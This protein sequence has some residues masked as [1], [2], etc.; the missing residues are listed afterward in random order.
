MNKNFDD[1]PNQPT[2]PIKGDRED[3]IYYDRN[4]ENKEY[5]H[6]TEIAYRNKGM[7]KTTSFTG[8][9]FVRDQ[10]GDFHCLNF[11]PNL[12]VDLT[13]MPV[14]CFGGNDAKKKMAD[15]KINNPDFEGA[16]FQMPFSKTNA[17]SD[18]EIYL[19]SDKVLKNKVK[20]IQPTEQ[21]IEEDEDKRIHLIFQ[22][23]SL[24]PRFC[25]YLS[26][27]DKIDFLEQFKS[28]LEQKITS[29]RKYLEVSGQMNKKWYEEIIL[30]P[31]NQQ[32]W[33]KWEAKWREF[34]SQKKDQKKK[35][36]IE[37]QNRF[38][39]AK[40]EIDQT[41]PK[42]IK[43]YFSLCYYEALHQAILQNPDY[44]GWL[45]DVVPILQD[46]NYPRPNWVENDGK[47]ILGYLKEEKSNKISQLLSDLAIVKI[48]KDIAD[49]ER[50]NAILEPLLK[51]I[52]KT[53]DVPQP[54]VE[55]TKSEIPVIDAIKQEPEVAVTSEI[56]PVI[57]E[58]KTYDSIDQFIRHEKLK[59]NISILYGLK[60]DAYQK[61]YGRGRICAVK[62]SNNA[63]IPQV[64][65]YDPKIKEAVTLSIKGYQS[66]K[67]NQEEF[68]SI[69]EIT[70]LFESF[71][72]DNFISEYHD[73][74]FK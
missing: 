12:Q 58:Q 71:Y 67:I 8:D 74:D 54:T 70:K 66:K 10:K 11:K 23:H 60:C 34:D 63:Y 32:W 49:S 51:N 24:I 48:G 38:I 41:L 18:G 50:F 29:R 65:V 57:E 59:E 45:N 26:N 16:L 52:E 68:K 62:T 36:E 4:E 31:A 39:E 72:E 7:V 30:S 64:I 9:F 55:E 43:E 2:E 6:K 1:M 42:E 53:I 25:N 73:P 3:Y 28:E 27:N 35:L 22:E 21:K 14:V 47:I 44:V 61:Q 33:S 46:N 69:Q 13:K 5:T 56:E 19:M 40:N 17:F 20:F 37:K 15:F